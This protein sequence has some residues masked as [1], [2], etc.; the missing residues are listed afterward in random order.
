MSESSFISDRFYLI[1][2]VGR[3]AFSVGLLVLLLSISSI[4]KVFFD[5]FSLAVLGIYSVVSLFIFLFSKR[6][7]LFE[8]LLDELFLFLLVL[9]GAFS[10][11]FFS[12]FLFFPV[13][14]SELF[15]GG[16]YGYLSALVGIFLQFLYFIVVYGGFGFSSLIQFVLNG[17]ALVLMMLASK[18]L[19]HRF[20]SQER[21]IRALE[22]E[23]EDAELYKRLYEISADLAHELKNPLA[24]IK[25]AV[26]LMLEGKRSDRLLKIVKRESERL[27]S[28]IKDFLNLAR[29]FSETKVPVSLTSVVKDILSSVDPYGKRIELVGGEEELFVLAD[30]RAIRSAVDN[31]VRNALQWSRDRVRITLMADGDWASLFV[32]DD[33]PGVPEEE[34]SR[35]FEPFFSKRS[36]GSGLGLAIVKKFVL[37]MGGFVIVDRSS[38]GGAKFIMKLPLYREEDEGF[39]T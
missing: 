8:F 3:L 21:Y 20:E 15:L 5:K 27:D 14:F 4:S 24:S 17:S 9:K 2:R 28:I 12:I 1:Y 19:K 34:R 39:S 11:T 25:G 26:E 32:E 10:Y 37:D 38:L 7:H 6:P 22:K 16:Y 13:F 35:I 30:P 23:R 29:P 31:L 18:K 33:G 36:D